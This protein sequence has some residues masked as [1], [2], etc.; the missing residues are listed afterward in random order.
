MNKLNKSLTKTKPVI[1]LN[2]LAYNEKERSIEHYIS[3][4]AKNRYGYALRNKGMK[5]DNYR[6]NPI[7]LYQHNTGGFFET[8]KPSET[9]IGSNISFSEDSKG[10]I[11]KTKFADT[12]LG[13]DILKMNVDGLL[14]SWSVGWESED[15]FQNVD[16]IPTMLDWEL[17]EYSSVIIPGN[18][19]AVNKMLSYATNQTLQRTLSV[20]LLISELKFEFENK[21]SELNKS[22]LE[23]QA[24][25][26]K[27][28][29]SDFKNEFKSLIGKQRQ[30]SNELFFSIISR[31]NN[32]ESNLYNS[33]LNKMPN[34]IE[35]VVRKYTGKID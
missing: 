2:Q 31:L 10:I 13:N 3:T 29:L 32:L 15:D 25:V 28:D 7:V 19:E 21:I 23:N 20:D 9:I 34:I 22:M 17:L 12:E 11:A 4:E 30:N 18:P 26:S 16:G 5:S 1:E 24:E 8:P 6:K 33:L 35:S 27:K 14:N